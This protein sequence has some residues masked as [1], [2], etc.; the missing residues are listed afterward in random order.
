MGY[1]VFTAGQEALAVDVNDYFMAQTVSRFT[2]A[3]Q[4]TSLLVS[5]AINQLSMLDDRPGIIQR[6]NGSAWVDN[7]T[8][9]VDVY[10]GASGPL[11]QMGSTVATTDP[12]GSLNVAFPQAFATANRRV[13]VNNGDANALSAPYSFWAGI[14]A[15]ANTASGFT[16]VCTNTA[17]PI[18]N[19]IV[20]LDWIAIG[21][22]P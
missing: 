16:A 13:V 17:G 15:A 4:R 22:R 10:G 2:G 1:K 6:W 20:R 5:P 14:L 9:M 11:I 19:T 18:S 8:T 7:T 12:Y 3:S 21:V